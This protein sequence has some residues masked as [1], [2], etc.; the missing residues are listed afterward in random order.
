[1]K[2]KDYMVGDLV[3]VNG[4]PMR[5]T[6]VGE[7]YLY[8][9]FDGNEGSLFEFY[10]KYPPEPIPL[11]NEIFEKNGFGVYISKLEEYDFHQ[12]FLQKDKPNQCSLYGVDISWR[13][14]VESSK[15]LRIETNNPPFCNIVRQITYVHELQ[16][17]L[18]LC[19]LDELADNFKI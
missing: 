10:K 8:A 4:F 17:A 7:D 6:S 3:Y 12:C 9:D 15:H 5:V 14:D 2:L 13:S 1:M 16:H 18:R 19:R 11:T